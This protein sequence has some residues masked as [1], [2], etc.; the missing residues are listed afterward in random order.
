WSIARTFT[1]T[2]RP[3]SSGRWQAYCD[4]LCTE[5]QSGGCAPGVPKGWQ[6]GELA[7]FLIL[8]PLLTR[9]CLAW[10]V[11]HLGEECVANSLASLSAR[12]HG[13]HDTAFNWACKPGLPGLTQRYT[14]QRSS[15]SFFTDGMTV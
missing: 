7:L 1:S 12:S 11:C 14:S 6:S 3:T 9:S 15:G 5:N 8:R 13:Q 4:G 10:R 2:P